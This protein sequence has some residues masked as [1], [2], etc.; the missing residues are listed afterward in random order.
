[1]VDTGSLPGEGMYSQLIDDSQYI[2]EAEQRI[3]GVHTVPS[4]RAFHGQTGP[5]PYRLATICLGGLCAVLL[6]TV[7]A[8][9]THYKSLQGL[10]E[11]NLLPQNESGGQ[12]QMQKQPVNITALTES[13]RKLKAEKE[14]CLKER[15]KLQ[16][17]LAK[18]EK[19]PSLSPPTTATCPSDWLHFNGS[20]YYI[21]TRS[22]TWPD[23][24]AWCKEKGGHLAIIL[25]AEE[26]E[27]LWNQ[28]PRGHWNAYWFGISDETAEADWLWVDGTKVIGGFWEVGE[29]NNHIDEDCGYIV[30]TRVLERKAIRS[31]YD[32]PC[33]MYWPYICEI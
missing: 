8:V 5:G 23:S 16:A 25:T 18:L 12:S 20:C 15:A 29:P 10:H 19:V 9:S 3:P 27:F 30:K 2:E 26:Q 24:Q 14:V 32:A 17:R 31:W 6:F 22:K 7:I 28:L 1:M 13:L 21:S 4:L 33:T 11:Q